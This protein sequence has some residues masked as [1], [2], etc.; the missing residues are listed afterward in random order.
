[1]YADI[2]ATLSFYCGLRAC[3]IKGLR[4]QDID[5]RNRLLHVRRSKTPA[6]WRSPTL[7]A[8]CL[9]VLQRLHDVR[10]GSG[11]QSPITS[12]SPGTGAARARRVMPHSVSQN[13]GAGGRVLRF[14]KEDWLLR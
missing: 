3:E 9:D 5:L 10:R 4:W 14:A 8:T 6:G 7:N 12:C 11:S 2:A 1:M 13:A